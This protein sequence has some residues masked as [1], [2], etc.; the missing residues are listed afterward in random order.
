ME[1][2]TAELVKQL[3]TLPEEELAQMG[4]SELLQARSVAGRDDKD[5]QKK[6]SAAEHR[7]F[8]REYTEENPLA[9]PG[10]ALMTALYQPYKM[11]KEGSRSEASLDQALSGLVGVKEGLGKALRGI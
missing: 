5:A 9:A 11:L 7:A 10:L 6:L 4:H 8:T 2:I 1:N 3:L